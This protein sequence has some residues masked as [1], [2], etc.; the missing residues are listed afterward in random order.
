MFLTAKLKKLFSQTSGFTLIE[1]LIV[2]VIIGIMSG[3]LLVIIDPQKQRARAQDGVRVG[4]VSKLVQS[5][6]AFRAGEGAYPAAQ[7]NLTDP[8][9]RYVQNWPADAAYTY[10]MTSNE[11]CISVPMAT[12]INTYIRYQSAGTTGSGGVNPGRMYTSC[13]AGCAAG[14]ASYTDSN[15]KVL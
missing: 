13:S 5:I 6:E 7:L 9:T 11:F 12:N 3:I 10:V 15:C 2:V 4:N 14:F 1:L 8:S